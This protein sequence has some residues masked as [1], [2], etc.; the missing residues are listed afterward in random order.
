MTSYTG[1]YLMAILYYCGS[2][3]YKANNLEV[4][5]IHCNLEFINYTLII[6]ENIK[7]FK[8]LPGLKCIWIT[9]LLC[10]LY[11]TTITFNSRQNV[12]LNIT[13]QVGICI[14][15]RNWI[16]PKYKC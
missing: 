15:T 14:K 8:P 16:N 13:Q 12:Y 9:N 5:K 7:Q 11:K 4:L 10:Q 3:N 1:Q 6:N 2:D